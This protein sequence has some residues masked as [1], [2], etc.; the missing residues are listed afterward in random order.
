MI[1][2]NS[3]GTLQWPTLFPTATKHFHPGRS[4]PSM[5]TWL[6]QTS[7]VSLVGSVVVAGVSTGCS[8][9]P[10]KGAL[11]GFYSSLL[12]VPR[13]LLDQNDPE[14]ARKRGELQTFAV[15]KSAFLKR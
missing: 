14:M 12:I 15:C 11:L 2:T 10:F 13:G 1:A 4:T 6:W 9:T 8:G 3:S 5:P 7:D